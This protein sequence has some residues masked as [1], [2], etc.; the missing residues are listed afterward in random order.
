M[1]DL[2]GKRAVVTGASSGIGQAIAIALAEAGADVASLYLG[3]PD[4]AQATRDA[5]EQ[6]GRKALLAEGDMSDAAG[7]EAFAQQVQDAWGGIDVWV[8]NAGKLLIR[9]FLEMREDEW[10]GLLA[11]N[12]H[13]YY[14]GAR[15]AARR[16]VAQG[17]GR[18]VNVTSVTRVQPATELTAYV[19][20]KAA[21]HGL[22][23]SLAVE[24]A[25]HGITVNA[26]APGAT[27]TALSG[28]VYSPQVRAA[29][30]ARIPLARIA[31]PRDIASAA[32]FFASDEAGYVTG[33]ELLAD[34]GLALNGDVG[35]PNTP[36]RD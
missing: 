22:T 16:M 27:D 34:G 17:G 6:A 14:Y 26:I 18:I 28:E 21:V 5:I 10:H 32:V 33:T 8:N 36:E 9:G 30:E 23:T 24:L 7:V 2:T 25:P 15:A 20:G 35:L 1:F 3:H 19:V 29:Y 11:T 4:G 31:Q 12:L 13:G